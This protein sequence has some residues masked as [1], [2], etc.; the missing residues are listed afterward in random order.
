MN[1]NYSITAN[2]VLDTITYTLTYAVAGNG[3]LTAPATSPTT[4]NSGAVVTITALASAGSHFVNWTGDVTTV[5]DVNA[6]S[7]T[8]T[9]NGNHSITANFVLDTY[10]LTYTAGAGGMISGTS[11]QTVAYDASGSAVTAVPNPGYL[12]V[13]WSDLSTANPRTRCRRDCQ[14]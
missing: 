10:T 11:P 2:F 13:Q 7:T 5:A 8:I 4:H 14:Y 1:G 6:A 12:F 3:S 9:M